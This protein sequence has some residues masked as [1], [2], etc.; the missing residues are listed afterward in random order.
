MLEC[1][2]LELHPG[3]GVC[4]NWL[5]FILC[6]KWVVDGRGKKITVPSSF[7]LK[8]K[9]YLVM[10]H[11]MLGKSQHENSS[12]GWSCQ[13]LICSEAQPGVAGLAPQS[14]LPH[15]AE[16]SFKLREMQ[17]RYPAGRHT[18]LSD[19]DSAPSLFL[20]RE[21]FSWS[22][23]VLCCKWPMMQM[24]TCKVTHTHFQ[25]KRDIHFQQKTLPVRA[26]E[27]QKWIHKFRRKD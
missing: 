6:Q 5:E 2:V 1:L 27:T 23:A 13:A 22:P 17:T 4:S 3:Q 15:Q 26:R 9:P 19:A 12:L 16:G 11:K 25:Q 20:S 14:H 21:K 7:V 24:R 10:N 8:R 18:Q